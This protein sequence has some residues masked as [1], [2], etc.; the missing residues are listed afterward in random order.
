MVYMNRFKKLLAITPAVVLLLGLT[1]VPVLAQNGADDATT[2]ASTTS[3]D[4]TTTSTAPR[5]DSPEQ[6]AE[7]THNKAEI[8]KEVRSSL[9]AKVETETETESNDILTEFKKTNKEH[10]K[11][12]RK[13]NCTAAEH[14]LET[15]LANLSKNASAFQVRVDGV[16]TKAVAFQKDS[17]LVVTNFDQLVATAQAAQTQAA[18]SVSALNSL[19]TN[20]DCTQPGV[21]QNVAAFK[22]ASSKARTDL[23]AYK[24]SVKAILTAIQAAKGVN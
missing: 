12:E 24:A 22:V 5:P 19:D 15:K 21:A 1:T 16:F 13:A 18:S 20:L 10:T 2:Q 8:N 6:E 3:T 11:E 17:N 23:K 4:T 7:T 9:K 14:G